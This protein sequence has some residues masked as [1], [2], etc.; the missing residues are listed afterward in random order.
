MHDHI[1]FKFKWVDDQGNEAGFLSKKGSFDGEMLVLDDVQLPAAAL[2]GVDNRGNRIVVSFLGE[3]GEVHGLIVAI[4][5][6]SAENLKLAL[7]RAR[8]TAWAERHREE[9]ESQ[10]RGHEFRQAVCP[11]C[12]ATIDLTGM[13]ESPQVYC[14]FCDT[15]GTV[16]AVEHAA[17]HEPRYRLCDECGMYSKPR[18]FTIFYFYFLLVVYGY[19]SKKTW[20]CPGCMRGEAWKMLFGNLLFLIG[21]PVAVMQ[22]FR[23]YGGTDLGS[24]YAGLDTANLKARRGNLRGAIDDYRKIIQNQPTTAGVKYNI[25]LACLHDNDPEKAARSFEF[26]LQDCANYAPA[27]SALAMCYERTGKTEELAE[28]KRRWGAASDDEASTVETTESV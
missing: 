23:S 2:T 3:D 18:Q 6:G 27:A 12:Q 11:H 9:L 8:S 26:A 15:I 5:S 14:S 21:V 24:L 13:P 28:L 10:G 1:S 22:L 20:R 25:G 17:R 4:T 7:G 16:D 19:W